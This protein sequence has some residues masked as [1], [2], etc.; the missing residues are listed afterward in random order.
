MPQLQF[1]Q[2][3]SYQYE[4]QCEVNFCH[5]NRIMSNVCHIKEKHDHLMIETPDGNLSYGMRQLN[6]IYTHHYTRAHHAVGHLL[7]GRLT[8]I[9]I[10]KQSSLLEV[11]RYAFLNPLRAH[12]VSNLSQQP[13]SRYGAM[14]GDEQV[15]TFLTVDWILS[16]FGSS[17][18][19]AG[20]TKKEIESYRQ[21]C[22]Q[23]RR[24][25]YSG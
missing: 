24:L 4:G 17:K 9:L 16:Q 18:K 6:G 7:R 2:L 25:S 13:W 22:R 5:I 10:E 8:S 11:C 14:A 15:P 3:N 20:K 23:R 21:V 19:S 1:N 12:L